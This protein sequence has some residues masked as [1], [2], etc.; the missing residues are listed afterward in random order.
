MRRAHFIVA[1]LLMGVTQPGVA[2]SVDERDMKAALIY[3]FSVYTTWPEDNA[4]VFNV[5]T[6]DD[7]QDNLNEQLLERK[8]INGKPV[9]V[10]HLHQME[11]V[12][13][14]QV[15]FVEEAAKA[16]DRR[17]R[18]AVKKYSVLLVDT[19]QNPTQTGMIQIALV[20]KRYHFVIDYQA[21]KDANLM[22]SSKLLRLATRVY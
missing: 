2:A 12:K 7:D 20:D 18:D 16:H 14:C 13:G 8:T 15:L 4:K 1:G 5:C 10:T 21:V 6:F 9:H 17:L 11:E 3:N 22:L 19:A